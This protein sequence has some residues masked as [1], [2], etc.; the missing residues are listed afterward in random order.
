MLMLLVNL[1][2]RQNSAA[3]GS[4]AASAVLSGAL[5]GQI[6][7]RE[8]A[9][10]QALGS[11]ADFQSAVSP[12]CIRQRA[13]SLPRVGLLQRL[14]ECNSAIQQSS[15]LRYGEALKD[16]GRLDAVDA[17]ARHHRG[18]FNVQRSTFKVCRNRTQRT[19]RMSF[20]KGKEKG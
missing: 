1:Q 7:A 13:G 9:E 10:W 6:G 3:Q 20:Q 17:R 19:Q 14:A 11:S 18:T 5:A 4:A 2:Q 15:T 8:T 12:N 16:S